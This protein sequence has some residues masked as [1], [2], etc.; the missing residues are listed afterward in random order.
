MQCEGAALYK[1][2]L[3]QCIRGTQCMRATQRNCPWQANTSG[4][5]PTS[6]PYPAPPPPQSNCRLF[7]SGALQ[8]C[9][10]A[11]AVRAPSSAWLPGGG[12]QAEAAAVAAGSSGG[13]ALGGVAPAGEVQ[14]EGPNLLFFG[15]RGQ[16]HRWGLW[17]GGSCI[18]IRYAF[19]LPSGVHLHCN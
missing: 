13:D 10:P 6:H 15:V 11:G 12:E 17:G 2:T 16:Q 7:Y 5:R 14:Q 8:A 19:A 18:A 1:R 4:P 3:S 9:A